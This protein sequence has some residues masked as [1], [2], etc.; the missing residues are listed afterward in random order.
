MSHS[1]RSRLAECN[2]LLLVEM[3]LYFSCL[4]RK[5]VRFE[6]AGQA[7]DHVKV[8]DKLAMRFHPVMTSSCR[9]EEVNGKPPLS[10]FP[11]VNPDAYIPHWLKIDYHKGQ[12]QGQFGY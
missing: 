7:K 11:I 12:W 8:N 10:D 6:E 2:A 1:A 3:E 4:L 9:V 5:Q